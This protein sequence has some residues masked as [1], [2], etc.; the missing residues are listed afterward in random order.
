MRRM[1]SYLYIYTFYVSI[2]LTS[3]II[4]ICTVY[5]FVVFHQ[6]IRRQD[7]RIN[8]EDNTSKGLK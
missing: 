2:H 1:S 7:F 4:P 8:I 6:T 5:P 3:T